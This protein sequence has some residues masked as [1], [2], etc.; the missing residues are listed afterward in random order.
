M[1]GSFAEKSLKCERFS[2]ESFIRE[3]SSFIDPYPKRM[4][5][6]DALST[7][8]LWLARYQQQQRSMQQWQLR[9]ERL[10][11]QIGITYAELTIMEALFHADSRGRTQ[12]ELV[13]ETQ[14]SAAQ[15]SGLIE[16]L[17]KQDWIVTQRA[18]HDR[19]RVLCTLTDGGRCQLLQLLGSLAPLVQE[20]TQ[21]NNFP[22]EDAA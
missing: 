9:L 10:L 19:R 5:G 16:T 21:L 7:I 15:V 4:P 20:A 6:M 8:H 3:T 22:W 12:V 17:V 13:R 2:T 14:F 1:T 11:A 18:P